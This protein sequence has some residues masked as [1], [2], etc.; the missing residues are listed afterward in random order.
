VNFTLPV[1]ESFLIQGA[2]GFNYTGI[3][4]FDEVNAE[5]MTA[6]STH[7]IIFGGLIKGKLKLG[8]SNIEE[9]PLANGVFTKANELQR[10]CA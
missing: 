6:V 4:P 9:F 1:T 3:Y 10:R 5:V 8:L 7:G 2:S